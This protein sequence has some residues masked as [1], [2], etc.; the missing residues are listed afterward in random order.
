M[1]AAAISESIN[2]L[3]PVYRETKGFIDQA[4]SLTTSGKPAIPELGETSFD[5]QLRS[6]I[7][8]VPITRE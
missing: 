1:D 2:M 8:S 6:L 3:N 5:N 4:K 7:D